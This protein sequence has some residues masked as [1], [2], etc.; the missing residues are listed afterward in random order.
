[1]SGNDYGRFHLSNITTS[2]SVDDVVKALRIQFEKGLETTPITVGD[3]TV[4]L[5]K[6]IT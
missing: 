2:L 5:S 1:M 3:L 4:S 6:S